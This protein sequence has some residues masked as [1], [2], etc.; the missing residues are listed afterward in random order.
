MGY[1]LAVF[2]SVNLVNRM[3]SR[4]NRGDEYFGMVRAPH[5]IST[6]GCNFALRFEDSK[7]SRVKQVSQELAIPINGIYKEEKQENGNKV[8]RQIE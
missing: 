8:Y 4:L 7:L 1:A 5:C 6:G 3:K 2:S